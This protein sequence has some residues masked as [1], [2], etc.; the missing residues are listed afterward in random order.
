MST[1]IL[2]VMTMVKMVDSYRE[3]K[4]IFSAILGREQVVVVWRCKVV[5]VQE[6]VGEC[7][8]RKKDEE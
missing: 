4:D 6:N 1:C 5:F 7:N 2:S 8:M 3:D